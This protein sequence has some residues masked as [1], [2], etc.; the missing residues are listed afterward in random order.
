MSTNNVTEIT[1]KQIKDGYTIY[2]QHEQTLKVS[3]L[4]K[5]CGFEV[6]EIAEDG[7]TTKYQINDEAEKN[8]NK[9]TGTLSDSVNIKFTNDKSGTIPTGV[10]LSATG[11]IVLGIIV[12]AGI[13]FFGIRS[14]K[15][16]EED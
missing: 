7:Y 4:P 13:V 3:G 8:G 9:A 11:L 14:K 15:K 10:I 1:G 6:E 12:V 5:E 2:L 16:Y